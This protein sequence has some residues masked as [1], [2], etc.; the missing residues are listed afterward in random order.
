MNSSSRIQSKLSKHAA[1]FND[2]EI[3]LKK[4]I[5]RGGD[6]ELEKDLLN[7]VVSFSDDISETIN[8]TVNKTSAILELAVV[9]N[10][11]Q[12][13]LIC[14]ELLPLLIELNLK[15]D[16]QEIMI[17]HFLKYGDYLLLKIIP[18]QISSIFPAAYSYLAA[19]QSANAHN[20]PMLVSEAENR[21]NHLQLQILSPLN[22]SVKKKDTPLLPFI[23]YRQSLKKVRDDYIASISSKT[24]NIERLPELQQK[25]TIGLTNLV[26]TMF[27]DC[28]KVFGTLP[29]GEIL[30]LFLGSFSQ[31]IA[32]PFS[33]IECVFLAEREVLNESAS[34]ELFY[35]VRDLFR[36]ALICLGET[37]Q[38][39]VP[40][41]FPAGLHLD[42]GDDFPISAKAYKNYY[43]NEVKQ[44]CT[45]ASRGEPFNVMSGSLINGKVKYG[46]AKIQ[47]V[48]KVNLKNKSSN[49]ISLI[50]NI[51]IEEMRHNLFDVQKGEKIK[52]EQVNIKLKYSMG[53]THIINGLCLFNKYLPA[54]PYDALTYLKKRDIIDEKLYH[55]LHQYFLQVNLLRSLLQIHY[56]EQ[57]E[58]YEPIS[59]RAEE[60][61]KKIDI[62]Y[63]TIVKPLFERLHQTLKIDVQN[64]DIKQARNELKKSFPIKLDKLTKLGDKSH[65]LNIHNMEEKTSI[66]F[67][68]G[69]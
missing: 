26:N 1:I 27:T 65:E 41:K 4:I 3:T 34:G 40:F 57:C 7:T 69:K 44:A 23:K 62:C 18:D 8:N 59:K 60:L 49:K 53:L 6:N 33:D 32:Q 17:N 14:L 20:L 30:I 61:L 54:S 10:K 15:V 38:N 37:E 63:Y 46:Y 21:I 35:H 9:K 58:K 66:K 16:T 67:N 39:D 48:M 25:L 64:Y 36:F 68:T 51:G 52:Q 55:H 28:S 29:F 56:G 47:D 22:L 5:K 12:L 31:D 50:R 19:L 24:F 11:D 43:E 45:S 42:T 2:I 13:I